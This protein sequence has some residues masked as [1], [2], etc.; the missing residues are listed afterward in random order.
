MVSSLVSSITAR[1][2]RRWA[3]LADDSRS[4]NWAELTHD[5]TASILSRLGTVDILTK[6]QMVCVTWHNICKDPAMWRTIYMRNFFNYQTYLRYDIKKMCRHA[7]DRSS[8]NVVDIIVDDFCTD[9]LLKYI[10]DMYFN[11]L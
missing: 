11:F 1:R 2:I 10:T 3:E 6:A 7:V 5:V 9:E 8:G 4:R